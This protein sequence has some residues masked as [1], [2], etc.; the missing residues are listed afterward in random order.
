MACGGVLTIAVNGL[1]NTYLTFRPYMKAIVSGA[2]ASL[3]DWM[4]MRFQGVPID[5]LVDTWVTLRNRGND[6]LSLSDLG[7][8][9]LAHQ[10][11]IDPNRPDTFLRRI[12]E[13]SGKPG[14]IE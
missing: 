12:D 11:E 2:E 1:L 5:F 3:S 8:I 6:G 9:Y 14:S 13:R 10:H 7:S 4:R